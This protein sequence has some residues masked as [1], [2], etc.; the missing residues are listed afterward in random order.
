[1]TGSIFDHL[2]M[3]K[4]Y[5]MSAVG[6]GRTRGTEP[7]VFLMLE[8]EPHVNN[9]ILQGSASLMKTSNFYLGTIILEFF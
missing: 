4:R 6:P 7:Q 5:L 2:K 9:A 1:M 8:P 3:L